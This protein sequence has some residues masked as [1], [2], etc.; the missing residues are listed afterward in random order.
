MHR[1]EWAAGGSRPLPPPQAAGS[2]CLGCRRT[3]WSSDLRCTL[4]MPAQVSPTLSVGSRQVG[5]QP[6]SATLSVFWKFCADS[7]S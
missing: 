6:P 7:L 4:R 2:A 5:A 1:P 3:I